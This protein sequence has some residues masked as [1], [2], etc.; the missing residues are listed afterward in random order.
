MMNRKN[1][2]KSLLPQFLF[3]LA[4]VTLIVMVGL[5]SRHKSSSITHGLVKSMS[6][7]IT[8]VTM[9]NSEK[10][11]TIDDIYMS[12]KTTGKNHD[13]RVRVIL[14][15]W[16]Q[17]APGSVYF[18]TDQDANISLQVNSSIFLFFYYLNFNISG[19]IPLTNRNG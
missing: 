5:L 8:K 1:E 3:F 6:R 19:T 4:V 15:T 2:Y 14:D 10:K 16:Y 17:R 11:L 7:V 9:K 13:T 18:F 12:V